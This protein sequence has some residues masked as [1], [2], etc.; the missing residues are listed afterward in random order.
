MNFKDAITLRTPKPEW[1]GTGPNQWD[2]WWCIWANLRPS[3]VLECKTASSSR[4]LCLEGIGTFM[5]LDE[6][7]ACAP[8][9]REGFPAPV[10]WGVVVEPAPSQ[11]LPTK[12][13]LWWRK[14][15]DIP[16]MV[17]GEIWFDLDQTKEVWGP[18]YDDGQWIGPCVKP[19]VP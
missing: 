14:D 17:S 7:V 8:V 5:P 19:E 12:D 13:G 3:V 2:S 11:A 10:G 6:L 15:R 9:A 16:V 1:F 4:G 18:V